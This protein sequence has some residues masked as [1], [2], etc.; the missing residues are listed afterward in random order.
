M[1][2][3]DLIELEFIDELVVVTDKADTGVYKCFSKI[4]HSR[5]M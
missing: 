2:K 5:E 3:W 4:R 1:S